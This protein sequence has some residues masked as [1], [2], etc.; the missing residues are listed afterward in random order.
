MESQNFDSIVS[1][2]TDQILNV[3]VI[4]LIVLFLISLWGVLRGVFILKYIKQP[5]LNEEI[6][7]EE[8]H[9]LKVQAKTMF[10][11]FSPVLVMSVIAL[12]WY[13]IAS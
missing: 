3:T 7:K 13:F 10:F 12:I 11:I 6:T 5:S 8:A 1:S 9:L 2:G 4:I